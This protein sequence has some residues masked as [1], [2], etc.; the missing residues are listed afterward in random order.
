MTEHHFERQISKPEEIIQLAYTK[1]D[2]GLILFALNK[3]TRW[4]KS[5]SEITSYKFTTN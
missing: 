3:V 1:L 4:D 2:K 5:A